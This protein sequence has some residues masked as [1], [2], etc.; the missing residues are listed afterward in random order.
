MGFQSTLRGLAKCPRSAYVPPEIPDREEYQ[1][2]DCACQVKI[3]PWAVFKTPARGVPAAENCHS[4]AA[5]LSLT[6]HT[7]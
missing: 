3:V 1:R 5:P 6:E 7:F 4:G 2:H